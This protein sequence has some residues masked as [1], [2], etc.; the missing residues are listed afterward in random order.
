MS[1]LIDDIVKI[2]LDW[3]MNVRT[4]Y[5]SRCQEHPRVFELMRRSTYELWSEET[6]R[7]YLEHVKSSASNGRNLM[8][9]RY[10]RM[11]RM[12]PPIN[13]NPLIEEIVEI[14]VSWTEEIFRKYPH[15][16]RNDS[17]LGFKIYLKCELETYSDEVLELYYRDLEG[18]KNE[19]RNL[20]QEK[21]LNLFKKIGYN[22][23]D[24]VEE[25]AKGKGKYF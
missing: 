4:I 21:Y 18:A 24:E 22:S 3:F 2:E 7:K 20:V 25:S 23:L 5:P 13:L 16:F 11:D 1:E 12:I 17:L 15:I 14:E 9:E 6:L 8:T 10:A 19:G